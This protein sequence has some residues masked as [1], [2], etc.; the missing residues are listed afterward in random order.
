[1]SGNFFYIRGRQSGLVL[2]IQE[3][4]DEPGTP[5]CLWEETFEA[6]QLWFEDSID[7]C[8]RSKLNRDLCLD[9]DDEG[10]LVVGTFAGN[11]NQ[12]WEY[13]EASGIMKN[14]KDATKV[15]DVAGHETD[16]GARVCV[17][18]PTGEDNQ[19]FDF[20]YQSPQYFVI[21]SE[22]NGK[23]IDIK[24]ADASSGAKVIMYERNDEDNQVFYQ[25]KDGLIRSKLNDFAFESAKGLG[26]CGKQIKLEPRKPKSHQQDWT[27]WRE[28]I[29]NVNNP[30]KDIIEIKKSNTD[31]GA[32]VCFDHWDNGDNQKW[33]VEYI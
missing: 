19:L 28:R 10:T 30:K 27:I 7:G 3:S 26:C 25:D 29:A 8:I 17:W 33:R 22:L 20:E 15:F 13:E 21:I 23:V 9:V 32:A 6:N 5:V 2:D 12:M 1:M 11:D 31:D 4:A 24:D 18:E 14:S 16:P